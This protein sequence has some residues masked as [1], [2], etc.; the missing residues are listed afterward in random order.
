MTRALK[1]KLDGL[2]PA[3]RADIEAE[4]DRLEPK[5][6]G[7]AIPICQEILDSLE[8]PPEPTEKAMRAVERYRRRVA[9]SGSTGEDKEEV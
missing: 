3:R 2:D 9:N 8:S 7:E 6:G 1:D 5:S 4:A